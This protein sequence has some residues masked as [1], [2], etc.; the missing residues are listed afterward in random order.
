MLLLY[1]TFFIVLYNFYKNFTYIIGLFI[2][3]IFKIFNIDTT[4]NSNSINLVNKF[5]KIENARGV[6]DKVRAKSDAK[7]SE[8][9]DNADNAKKKKEQRN[10]TKEHIIDVLQKVGIKISNEKYNHESKKDSA[11]SD[12]NNILAGHHSVQRP[13][14]N[15][16]MSYL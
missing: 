16:T 1:F 11:E 8:L 12:L 2:L 14:I 4:I 3:I 5:L 10:P 7:E 13:I 9:N 15:N 6:M